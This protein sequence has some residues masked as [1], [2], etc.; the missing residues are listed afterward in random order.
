MWILEERFQASGEAE[1][2][3]S[4]ESNVDVEEGCMVL[5]WSIKN[6]VCCVCL[7]KQNLVVIHT[8]KS[9]QLPLSSE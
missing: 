3:L 8:R 2:R 1:N 9:L 7:L 5:P 4:R 6:I